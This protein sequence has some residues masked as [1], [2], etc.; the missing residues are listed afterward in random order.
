MYDEKYYVKLTVNTLFL[1]DR[2]N[3]DQLVEEQWETLETMIRA[4]LERAIV[5]SSMESRRKTNFL[6]TSLY[7]AHYMSAVTE[8]NNAQIFQIP[9]DVTVPP[10][11][12]K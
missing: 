11:T 3:T 2:W 9:L 1:N 4:M 7:F 10:R 12:K 8:S 5:A 6:S